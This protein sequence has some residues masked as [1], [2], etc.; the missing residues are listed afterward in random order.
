MIESIVAT[1]AQFFS[2]IQLVPQIYQLYITKNVEG[3]SFYYLVLLLINGFLWLLHGY[4]IA[5]IALINSSLVSFTAT[6][7]LF[8]MYI[9]YD[10]NEKIKDDNDE[11]LV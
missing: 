4:F 5:D 6:I 1:L 2:C 10:K 3:I 11:L 9:N 7:L 8:V